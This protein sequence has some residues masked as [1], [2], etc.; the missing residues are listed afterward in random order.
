MIV[1]PLFK[2]DERIDV[3]I[4]CYCPVKVRGLYG[5]LLKELL[6]SIM[7]IFKVFSLFPCYV[8]GLFYLKQDIGS[9]KPLIKG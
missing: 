8:K 3:H 4:A 7:K 1:S 6:L 9:Q 2:V 5:S